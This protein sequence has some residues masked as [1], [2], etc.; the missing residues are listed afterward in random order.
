MY[1]DVS[2]GCTRSFG[3]T[4]FSVSGYPSREEAEFAVMSMAYDAGAWR[5]PLLRQRW[6]QLWRPR[7]HSDLVDR[8][9][10]R[11]TTEGSDNG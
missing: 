9:I 2:Y 7:Q 8:L 10:A 3:T 4:T 6:W 5:P 11:A 1:A